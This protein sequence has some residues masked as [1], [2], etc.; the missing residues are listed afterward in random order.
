MKSNQHMI[1][2]MLFRRA[3]SLVHVIL[4]LLLSSNAYV[5]AQ[6]TGSI[7]GTVMDRTTKELLPYVNVVVQG[8]VFG[9]ASGPMGSFVIEKI[10]VGTY[11]ITFSIVGYAIERLDGIVVRAGERT[12]ANASLQQTPVQM[13][14]VDVYGA[15][16][17]RERITD[18]PAAVS[19]IEARDFKLNGGLAQLPKLLDAEPGIEIVQSGLND[20]NVN[21][22]GFNSSLNRR[23]QVMLDGRDLSIAFL[24]AQEWNG[25]SV[26]VED[27]GRMEVV[28]GPSS[29]LYGANAF[30]GVINI[31]SLRPRNIVG[32]K[33]TVAGG[34]L[35]TVRTDVRHAGV[36]GQ[37]GYKVNIG[38][39]QGNSWSANRKNLSYEYDG[40]NQLLNNEEVDFID[41]KI[42]SSYAS[43]RMDY[44]FE[45]EAGSTAEAGITRVENEVYVT[46]I[47]RVQVP[48]AL[49]PW[50]RAS[51]SNKSW[52]VQVWG[53]GRDSRE[54]QVSLAS[55]LPLVE[56]SFIGQSDVQFRKQFFDER[57][58]FIAGLALRLQSIDTKG[59]LMEQARRDNAAGIYAQLE[60]SLTS[61]V[62]FVGAARYDQSTLHQPQL[63]PKLAVVWMPIPD[64]SFRVT[65]N[66]AFQAPN[67]SEL[68]LYV[69]RTATN[70]YTGIKS[71]TAFHGY[72]DL[73]VEKITG[74]EVGY[75]GILSKS[76]F[77]TFDLYLNILHDFITDLAPKVHPLYP[78]ET[79]LPG[80]TT[81]DDFGLP[82]KRSVWSYANA[83]K[84]REAGF[85]LSA[86]YYLTDLFSLN[87]SYAYFDHAVIDAPANVDEDNFFPNAPRHKLNGGVTY[88]SAF[89]LEVGMKM[90]YVPSFDW[91]A[92]IY[93]GRVLAYTLIDLSTRYHVTSQLD[94]ALNISNLFDRVHYEIFG[95][96]LLRRRAVASVTATF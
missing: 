19:V 78:T 10:P 80:D 4:L 67:L 53:A 92:G 31:Q 62:R 90:K 18:V 84:V 81:R 42:A 69:L 26:P 5:Y 9:T 8:T 63:S 76:M 85:E 17:R 75:K 37:W 33:V 34:E 3:C 44:D 79:Y 38:R 29:A 27:L 64:H 15:S 47:G 46:G 23:L 50:A 14:E 72:S 88:S 77:L 59:T 20:F 1:S 83:G 48:N 30:N 96:S 71:Y 36:S 65:F 89:G 43:A 52:Y 70:P 60:Y 54:P 58:F 73:S 87:A 93:K 24:G 6:T 16:F 41:R 28:R 82:V 40:F 55:G 94:L 35:N 7:T 45:G 51:F 95:G 2:V 56:R 25:L 32:T 39:F 66:K 61:H 22:R 49:K 11:T 86:N 13:G 57:L 74:Y 12:I 21:T 91:A 68:Y